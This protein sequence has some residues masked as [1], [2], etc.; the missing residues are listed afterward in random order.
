MSADGTTL[1]SGSEDKTVKIWD[2][3]TGECRATLWG[4]Q[5]RVASVA[6]SADGTTLASGAEDKSERIWDLVTNQC[7]ATLAAGPNGWVMFTAD[8][9]YKSGGNPRDMAAHSIGLCRYEL[10]TSTPDGA[11]D[12]PGELDDLIAGIRLPP[13]QLLADLGPWSPTVRCTEKEV[14][15]P[16]SGPAPVSS[17]LSVV[18]PNADSQPAATATRP[19]SAVHAADR[20]LFAWLHLSDLHF[21]HGDAE[22]GWDQKLVLQALRVDVQKLVQEGRV[23]VPNCILVTGDI[24]FSGATRRDTEYTDASE[25]LLAVAADL[26][27][28]AQAV[29]LVPGNHDVQRSADQDRNL[30]RLVKELRAGDESIDEVVG[31]PD[32]SALLRRRQANYWTFARSFAVHSSESSF[33]TRRDLR[34]G[35]LTVRI[36]GL[37][38]SML[39]ADD[40]DRGR[41]R[42]GKGALAQL[43]S[44]PVA[45]QELVIAMSHHPLT[46]GWLADEREVEAWLRR[47]AHIHL[48]GHVHEAASEHLRT[49]AR[50]ELIRVT[51]GAAHGEKSP[52]GVP[53]SHGYNFASV[54]L[55]ADGDLVLR[56][57]P[58]RFSDTN[59]DFRADV[60]N[61][62]P[63]HP[64]AEHLLRLPWPSDEKAT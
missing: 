42:V 34:F 56:I 51:A 19:L 46:G 20:I 32:D 49:G 52:P 31:N 28:S 45:A 39:A 11:L 6:L 4:H 48:S 7:L 12:E 21:G 26:K 17:P 36:L 1:A 37:N 27:L 55:T 44:T 22:H 23:S 62:H 15:P 50:G 47:H 41:L 59:K 13:G 18:E 63:D 40:Q 38:T 58:R 30:R 35:P 53:V 54:V 61:I 5:G 24:A 16:K 10:A 9:R 33:H 3:R 29:Y 25:Y 64:Y 57:V 43:L 60:D 8:G 2:A 14:V